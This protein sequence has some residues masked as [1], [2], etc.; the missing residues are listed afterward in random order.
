MSFSQFLP[1]IDPEQ[2]PDE[3][4][5]K[6][7]GQALRAHL[8]RMALWEHP[9]A[10]LGYGDYP[11]WQAVF[12]EGDAE[13]EPTLDCYLEAVVRRYGSLMGQLARKDN[14]DGLVH[15]NIKRFIL[16][17]QKAGDPIGYAVF[18]NL[19]ATLQD[20]AASGVL[21]PVPP[22]PAR[23]VRIRNQ[24][25]LTFTPGASASPAPVSSIEA[26][27]GGSLEWEQALPR[28]SKLG[29]G[30][31]R[32][33]RTCLRGLSGSGIGT[34]RVGDLVGPL[35]TRAREAYAQRNGLT[36]QEVVADDA[37]DS[38]VRGLIRTVR[39]DPG[40]QEDSEGLQRLLDCVEQGIVR[41]DFQERTR[42][43]L[44]RLVQELRQH[45]ESD[46]EIPSWAE[47]ARQ[48]GARKATLWDHVQRLREL[49]QGCQK[50]T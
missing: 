16:K 50:E 19:E 6:A 17:R 12:A 40:Y 11:S 42:E 26:L 34:F 20:L 47:L 22:D 30:A 24:T 5:L 8:K 36:G 14:V 33:L 13:A 49:V 9:P 7:V 10:Y 32:L 45:V 1:Q 44:R 23:P 31:Q 15:L 2:Y 4:L 18:K 27:L 28:L 35:K 37:G 21:H 48:L 3:A 38:T 43:G 25:V 46:E 29:K 39:A 41:Q